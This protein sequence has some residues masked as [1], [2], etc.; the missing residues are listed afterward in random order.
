MS[1]TMGLRARAC[2]VFFPFIPFFLSFL[3]LAL[4]TF[5]WLPHSFDVF[6]SPFHTERVQLLLSPC[7]QV[8]LLGLR[9]VILETVWNVS[10]TWDNHEGNTLS[11]RLPWNPYNGRIIFF[12]ELTVS[13]EIKDG[14]TVPDTQQW[15]LWQHW[16]WHN[17]TTSS[18]LELS[19][20]LLLLCCCY[21]QCGTIY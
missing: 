2:S 12:S 4:L 9:L 6:Y 16:E 5:P 18:A 7:C 3:S 15:H 11:I 21:L 20:L 13:E 8:Q 19:V 10:I 1:Q 17:A 14:V